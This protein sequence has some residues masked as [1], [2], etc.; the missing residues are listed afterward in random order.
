[1]EEWF[2]SWFDTAYYHVLYKERDFEEAERFITNLFRHLKPGKKARVLDLACGKGRHAVFVNSLGY[3][4]TGVDLSENSI[5]KAKAFENERLRFFRHD[6]REPLPGESYDVVLNLFTS[7][8]YF[9]DKSENEAVIKSIYNTLTDDGY[10]VIDFLNAT[11]VRENLIPH[12]TINRGN[13]L[14]DISKK[15]EQDK[16]VKHIRFK[17]QDGDFY[18]KEQVQLLELSDFQDF[19]SAADFTIEE[20][21]GNYDLEPFHE[22]SERLIII[23]KKEK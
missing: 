16:V 4:T 12:T 17:D 22:G 11:Y 19:L 8:G 7:F 2:A 5:R 14:F 9:D 18:F 23:A 6:M 3:D 21:F 15:I 20:V 13:I 1:M 10:L